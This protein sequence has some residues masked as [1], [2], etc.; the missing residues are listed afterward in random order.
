LSE[1]E[2]RG[3]ERARLDREARDALELVC[4]IRDRGTAAHADRLAVAARERDAAERRGLPHLELGALR[5]LRLPLAR[6]AA[7]ATE[8]ARRATGATPTA[9]GTTAT[10]EAAAGR[11]TGREAGTR[12]GAGTTRTAGT[13]RA[14]G[15]A[16]RLTGLAR[17]EAAR[18]RTRDAPAAR[19]RHA[20]RGRI[21]VVARTRGAGTL[22]ALRGRVWVVAR[23]RGAGTR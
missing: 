16:A 21:R 14:A 6:L 13:A 2:E 12:R 5:P 8:S 20:L 7:A 15:T 19:A 4:E 11:A 9:A 22:H 10:G 23:T 1:V 18:L 17:A 3:H